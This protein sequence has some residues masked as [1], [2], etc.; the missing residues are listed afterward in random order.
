MSTNPKVYRILQWVM[1]APLLV[2]L[3]LVV[4]AVEGIQKMAGTVLQQINA[5]SRFS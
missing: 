1:F 3:C 5:E 2:P 4:G